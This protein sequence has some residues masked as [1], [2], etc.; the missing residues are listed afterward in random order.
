MS[1]PGVPA[2]GGSPV[3]QLEAFLRQHRTAAIA[4]GGGLVVLLALL[5]RKKSAAT[6]A[7]TGNT[8]TTYTPA[9][10]ANA[11]AAGVSGGYDSTA[12][13]IYNAL[14]PGMESLQNRVDVLEKG[15]VLGTV[16]STPA[17]TG[18]GT[19]APTPAPPTPAPTPTPNTPGPTVSSGGVL[20]VPGI[21]QGPHAGLDT[22][23][24]M[25]F[26]GG[27][28]T[29]KSDGSGNRI[30]VSGG[31]TYTATQ[32]TNLYKTKYGSVLT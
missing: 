9:G 11:G 23:A 10:Y 14:Q 27:P 15:S 19:G 1:T 29:A 13:D 16:P 21:T 17:P 4:G 12:S 25:L 3:D 2:A 6:A 24:G 20:Q 5:A 28:Y 32:V 8:A 7:A 30:Y 26:G 22:M 31:K 18:T